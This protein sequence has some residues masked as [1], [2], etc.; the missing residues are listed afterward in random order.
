MDLELSKGEPQKMG[1]AGALK[2]MPGF[3]EIFTTGG[4]EALPLDPVEGHNKYFVKPLI[5]DEAIVRSS[6]TCSAPTPEGYQAAK[7]YYE[8]LK[9]GQTNV[10][11]LMEG[12]RSELKRL[13]ELPEGTGI[14]LTPSRSDAQFIPLLIAK[15]LNRDQK[16]FLNILPCNGEIGTST[17]LAAGGKYF[18]EY[19]PIEG[20]SEE[21][22]LDCTID[23]PIVGLA[24]GVE[25]LSLD[26]RDK[27]GNVI[28]NKNQIEQAVKRCSDE[29]IVPILHSVFP[30]GTGIQQRAN[31]DLAEQINALGGMFVANAYQG[32]L[33]KYWPN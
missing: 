22:G 9:S 30:S 10:D 7:Y 18:S 24:E 17:P 15:I 33:E 2:D 23:A 25:V 21:S 14:I 4:D 19:Q 29:G 28:D 32:R 12:I 20:Y 13:Y 27:D 6:C 16:K 26:A 5:E 3:P 31:Y 1:R 11:D 8:Q